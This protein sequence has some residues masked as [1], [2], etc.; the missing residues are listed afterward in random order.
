V[1][2][3]NPQNPHHSSC[4]RKGKKEEVMDLLID[5]SWHNCDQEE[6][7]IVKEK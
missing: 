2:K 7:R 6:A 5:L 4:H 1:S 3:T